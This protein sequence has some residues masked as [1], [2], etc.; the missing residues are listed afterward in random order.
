VNEVGG[1]YN[2][3]YRSHSGSKGGRVEYSAVKWDSTLQL[4]RQAMCI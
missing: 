3:V 4:A 2:P 1:G